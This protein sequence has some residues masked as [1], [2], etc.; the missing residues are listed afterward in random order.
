MKIP[1]KGAPI[2]LGLLV[3]VGLFVFFLSRHPTEDTLSGAAA[4]AAGENALAVARAP[5]G[6]HVTPEIIAT[7]L[8][9]EPG[10]IEYR[11]EKYR[12]SF[13]RSPQAT[14]TE[15]DEGGGAIT[16]TYENFEKIRGFQVFI[17]P[18][19]GA[20][21]SEERFARDVPSGVRTNVENATLDGVKAVT[22]NS[23]DAFLGDT[24]EIWVIHNG[25][26]YE[27]TTFTG[28]ATWFTPIISTWRFL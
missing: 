18:Y 27:I 20:T 22:F 5:S 10:R 17:V 14:V 2:I 13:Y 6:V 1:L 4:V 21:I 24:R 25:Y 3:G 7:Q 19:G 8:P 9:P 28:V 12:F 26:L 23:Y 16:V 15:Y 11:N